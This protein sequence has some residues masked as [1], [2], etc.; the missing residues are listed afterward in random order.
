MRAQ[1]VAERRRDDEPE[2]PKVRRRRL[3]KTV[4]EERPEFP[5]QN[6]NFHA[7][8]MENK[9]IIKVLSMLSTCTQEL[10]QVLFF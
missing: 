3:Y 8:V 2:D 7:L 9:E 1:I 6:R 5:V 4:S 10:G